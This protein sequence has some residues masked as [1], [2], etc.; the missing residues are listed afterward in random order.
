MVSTNC[1]W[2]YWKDFS[3]QLHNLEKVRQDN[4][5][6][7]ASCGGSRQRKGATIHVPLWSLP[8]YVFY[9]QHFGDYCV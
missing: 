9:S 6:R 1:I 2:N 7:R 8:F 3:L 5:Q 4:P